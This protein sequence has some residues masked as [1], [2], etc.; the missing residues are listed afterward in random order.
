MPADSGRHNVNTAICINT[1]AAGL[2]GRCVQSWIMSCASRTKRLLT[3]RFFLKLIFQNLVKECNI[4]DNLLTIPTNIKI[5]VHISLH[6]I[7]N[8]LLYIAGT[9]TKIDKKETFNINHVRIFIG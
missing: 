9:R 2:Q 3:T 4:N 6:I 8:L 1:L 5:G 7:F